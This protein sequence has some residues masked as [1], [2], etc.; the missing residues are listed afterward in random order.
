MWT[1]TTMH[2]VLSSTFPIRRQRRGCQ[3]RVRRARA[4]RSPSPPPQPTC[5]TSRLSSSPAPRPLIHSSLREG[6]HPRA[7][8]RHLPHRAGL[9]LD[10]RAGSRARAGST[11]RT[12]PRRAAVTVCGAGARI[13]PTRNACPW[14]LRGGAKRGAKGGSSRI[15]ASGRVCIATASWSRGIEHTPPLHLMPYRQPR[16]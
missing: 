11:G 3:S 5:E 2:T 8:P 4:R 12:H 1:T 6:W 10:A 9:L 14:S 13:A 7:L 15:I 16:A